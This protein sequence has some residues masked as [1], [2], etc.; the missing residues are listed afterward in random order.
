MES[1]RNCVELLVGTL[2]LVED[3]GRRGMAPQSLP[4]FFRRPVACGEMATACLDPCKTRLSEPSIARET[5]LRSRLPTSRAQLHIEQASLLAQQKM[6]HLSPD[7]AKLSIKNFY[8]VRR[9]FINSRSG[10]PRGFEN[11]K[12]V[13]VEYCGC[14][15]RIRVLRLRIRYGETS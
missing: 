12:L 10:I 11:P 13:G 5:A 9:K 2:L 14:R 15:V 7:G 8:Q 3:S 4:R 1:R 6:P